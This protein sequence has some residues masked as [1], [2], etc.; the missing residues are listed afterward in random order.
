M[1]IVSPTGKPD[2]NFEAPAKR[3]TTPTTKHVDN[4]CRAYL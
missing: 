3:N 4:N 2:A 1:A